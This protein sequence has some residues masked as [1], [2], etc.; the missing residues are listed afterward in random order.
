MIWPRPT[1]PTS[2]VQDQLHSVHEAAVV[3]AES[4]EASADYSSLVDWLQEQT[5]REL[6]ITFDELEDLIGFPLPAEPRARHSAWTQSG[7]P[8]A[9]ALSAARYKPVGVNLGD[10]R[11]ILRAAGP[12][13]E[14]PPGN[15]D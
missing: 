11:S 10:E 6:P 7:E 5:Q 3:D 12:S 15:G 2:V 8:L 1:T 14:S 4:D 9:D 13:D